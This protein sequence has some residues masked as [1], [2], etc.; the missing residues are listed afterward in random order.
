MNCFL[1]RQSCPACNSKEYTTIYSCKF[2]ESPIK[3]FLVSF[4][5]P[6]GGIE[7]DYLDEAEYVLNECID[8]GMV[9]Q[10]QI[11]DDSLMHK[12]YT[13]WIDPNKTFTSDVEGRVLDYY[14][15]YAQ[16]IMMLI[17][18]FQTLPSKLA[19]LD[20]GMGWGS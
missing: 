13:E 4:Y 1:N 11:P 14:A 5:N 12:L 20:F 9:Y 17:A 2:I 7:F 18:Y 6:Q 8:C 10:K 3:E 19:F 16:E 15:E